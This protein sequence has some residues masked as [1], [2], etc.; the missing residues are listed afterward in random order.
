MF[1]QIVPPVHFHSMRDVGILNPLAHQRYASLLT[2]RAGLPCAEDGTLG[3]RNPLSG[4]A[5]GG[6]LWS[7]PFGYRASSWSSRCRILGAYLRAKRCCELLS[8]MLRVTEPSVSQPHPPL[9]SSFIQLTCFFLFFVKRATPK[10]IKERMASGELSG[11]LLRPR[12]IL[13]RQG[14]L[15]SVELLRFAVKG[16]SWV[17][18]AK[19][20]LT[21]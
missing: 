17:L 7:L 21:V 10:Q 18:K 8:L 3:A 20:L 5:A 15:A 9:C 4:L 14:R 1:G 6:S 13:P 11:K 19:H 12:Y 2:I 16:L